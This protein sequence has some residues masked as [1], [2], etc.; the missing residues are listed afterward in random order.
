MTEPLVKPIDL[1]EY[2][3][4]LRRHRAL[5]ATFVATATLSSLGFTYA[6]SER[7]KAQT[8]ILY[9]PREEVSFQQHSRDA[10]GFPP[11]LVPLESIGNTLEEMV[12]SDAIVAETVRVLH[13]DVKERP[14]TNS[15]YAAAFR[16]TKDTIKEWRRNA[17]EIL[18]HG[19]LLP[20]DAFTEA[21]IG[22][23]SDVSIKR[24]AKAYTFQL[25]VISEDPK[26]AAAIVDTIGPILSRFLASEH[27]RSARE[28]RDKILPRLEAAA[29]EINATRR[30]LEATKTSAGVASLPEELS[31]KV[32][33]TN[34]LERQ[35]TDVVNDL[36][37]MERRRD[38]LNS[39]IAAQE[40][41]FRYEST[42]ADNPIVEDMKLAVAR[43]ELERSGLLEKLTPEHQ[44][45]KAVDARLAQARQTQ[46]A[47]QARVVT[48]ELTRVNDIQRKL[49]SDKLSADAE[50][51]T[52]GAKERELRAAIDRASSE[53]RLLTAKEPK[54]GALLLQLKAGEQAY[55]LIHQSYEEARLAEARET[56]EVAILHAALVPIAPSRPI[57][58]VHVGASFV[59]SL[60]LAIG[61]AL[62][63]K[64]FDDTVRTI[65]DA[66]DALG[67]PVLTT[68]PPVAAEHTLLLAPRPR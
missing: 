15:W 32:E 26:R 24:T 65:H 28:S 39:Q 14:P 51:E 54:I 12:K 10:L 42:V 11:P 30:E 68:I 60:C 46:S 2:L 59:L 25:E 27:A 66:E 58:I 17:F 48:S 45:V 23:K 62:F 50:I 40:P 57:K 44:D 38:E 49:L 41:S 3:A 37:A 55:E 64:L 16:E 61:L 43:L 47:Q 34:R 19:R 9:Q 33:S 8:T 22:L 13:L 56:S 4:P 52:L 7:Y 20:R 18:K 35:L 36:R 6:V 53:A 67:A 21:M 5:I 29:G 1:S 63:T 31:L